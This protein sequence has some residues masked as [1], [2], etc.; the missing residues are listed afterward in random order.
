MPQQQ[1]KYVVMI[2]HKTKYRIEC[3]NYRS[4]SMVAH[5]G[6]ILLKIIARR[7]SEYCGRF[8][9]PAAGTRWFPTEPFYHRYDVCKLSATGVGAEE[10]YSYV[11]D[12]STLPKRTTPL[13]E[14]SSRQYS[15]VL[16]CHR[17]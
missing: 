11:I 1:W 16:A 13:T 15:P 17:I 14:P 6:T 8:R 10:A 4:I 5:A 12:L 9:D 3:G 7:L 2:L